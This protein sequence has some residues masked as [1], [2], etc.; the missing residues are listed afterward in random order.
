[1][2]TDGQTDPQNVVH[3]DSGILAT[4]RYEALTQ[5]TTWNLGDIM[6]SER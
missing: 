3:L 4:T 1:M 2:P 6:L 5:A